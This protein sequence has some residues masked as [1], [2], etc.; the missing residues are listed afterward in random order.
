MT[1]PAV[2]S[3]HPVVQAFAR[4]GWQAHATDPFNTPLNALRNVVEHQMNPRLLWGRR[5]ESV[6]IVNDHRESFCFRW[7]AR[8]CERRGEII[9]VAGVSAWNNCVMVEGRRSQHESHGGIS[10]R[11][12]LDVSRDSRVHSPL[13]G[14]PRQGFGDCR[15]GRETRWFSEGTSLNP[16]LFL[17]RP[18]RSL[19][20]SR[21]PV[22]TWRAALATPLRP[23]AVWHRRLSGTR[24]KRGLGYCD[25]PRVI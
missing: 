22:V 18:S 13:P 14:N 4:S 16:H 6:G 7:Q 24:L 25:R 8:P 19:D 23:P 3:F 5:I 12:K 11:E 17:R 9:V 15:L 1:G 20:Q 2:A 10:P 21:E